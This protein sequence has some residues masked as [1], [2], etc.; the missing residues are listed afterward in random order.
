M[1]ALFT[2]EKFLRVTCIFTKIKLQI[3]ASLLYKIGAHFGQYFRNLSPKVGEV[4]KQTSWT[5]IGADFDQYYGNLSPKV[6]EDHKRSSR[7]TELIS[8]KPNRRR[9]R[10]RP[11]FCLPQNGKPFHQEIN[12]AKRPC[13]PLKIASLA[14]G[15]AVLV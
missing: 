15:W 7:K 8:G 13:A 11:S 9:C 12:L 10:F 14:T 4:Q 1:R 2:G 5:Q 6:G 3:I